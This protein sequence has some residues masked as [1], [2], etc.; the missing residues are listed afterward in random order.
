[1]ARVLASASARDVTA[2]RRRGPC[3]RASMDRAQRGP[4][5]ACACSVAL[6]AV[7]SISV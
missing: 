5:A 7:A 2:P 4:T 6:V 3:L 1:L